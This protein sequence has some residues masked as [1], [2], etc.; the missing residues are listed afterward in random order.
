MKPVRVKPTLRFAARN[1]LP[2]AYHQLDTPYKVSDILKRVSPNP[3]EGTILDRSELQGDR[4]DEL[5]S[6]YNLVSKLH[7]LDLPDELSGWQRQVQPYHPGNS[8]TWAR[9]LARSTAQL[10]IKTSSAPGNRSTLLGVTIESGNFFVEQWMGGGGCVGYL[11]G[12]P[13]S[14]YAGKKGL[15]SLSPLALYRSVF[16]M[17]RASRIFPEEA[18][19]DSKTATYTI[20]NYKDS[21]V[22]NWQGKWHHMGVG[23]KSTSRLTTMDFPDRD[24]LP[25]M[26][27]PFAGERSPWCDDASYFLG[28]LSLRVLEVHVSE[29]SDPQMMVWIGSSN[30]MRSILLGPSLKLW[31]D[32]VN[33][34]E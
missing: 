5:P 31:E 13:V 30:S 17:V 8:V 12:M 29:G 26:N 2:T 25:R 3:A 16:E 33:A 21:L 23:N 32:M 14:F 11:L 20:T 4:F 9:R 7:P 15:E 18:V 6:I 19:A 34:M 27:F 24:A 1:G 10:K 28:E 22:R